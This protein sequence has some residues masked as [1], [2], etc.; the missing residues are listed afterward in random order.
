MVNPA[1]GGGRCAKAIPWL[2]AEMRRRGWRPQLLVSDGP[3]GIGPLVREAVGQGCSPVVVAGGDGTV[4]EAANAMVGAPVPLAILPLGSGND[5]VRS[6]GMQGGVREAL[7]LIERGR[8]RLVDVVEAEGRVFVGV[9]CVGFDAEVAQLANRLKRRLPP[10]LLYPACALVKLLT[11]RFRWVRLEYEGGDFR[12]RVLL[13]AFGNGSFYGRGMRILPPARMDDGLLDICLIRRVGRTKLLRS[14]RSV[15]RGGH[16]GQPEV[17]LART[18]WVR[19][20]GEPA[21]VM[22]GDGEPLGRLPRVLR[23]LPRALQVLAP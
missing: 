9:G 5:C 18:P 2:L 8:P 7:E 14:L 20:E 21:A 12:G 11:Y 10:S 17:R 22:Y 23:V 15:Y 16:L 6:L 3:G 19:V 1:A 13:V 4:N